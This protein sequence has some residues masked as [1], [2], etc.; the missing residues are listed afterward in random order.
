MLAAVMTSYDLLHVKKIEIQK[1][2]N[3]GASLYFEEQMCELLG[4]GE[5]SF[6]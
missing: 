3:I 4:R 5:G 1:F 6:V 2:Q